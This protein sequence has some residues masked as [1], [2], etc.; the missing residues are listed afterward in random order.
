MEHEFAA[1]EVFFLIELSGESVVMM[2][3][4]GQDSYPITW[5]SWL[6]EEALRTSYGCLLNEHHLLYSQ[7]ICTHPSF[8]V[9]LLQTFFFSQSTQAWHGN[10]QSPT[11][12]ENWAIVKLWGTFSGQQRLWEQNRWTKYGASFTIQRMML[13]SGTDIDPTCLPC[14]SRRWDTKADTTRN[15]PWICIRNCEHCMQKKYSWGQQVHCG[16]F[17]CTLPVSTSSQRF[18]NIPRTSL[19]I[20]CI[21]TFPWCLSAD[22]AA[23][24]VLAYLAPVRCPLANLASLFPPTHTHLWSF[25]K[26]ELVYFSILSLVQFTTSPSPGHKNFWTCHFLLLLF[27]HF[28]SCP[29]VIWKLSRLPFSLTPHKNFRLVIFL[30]FGHCLNVVGL[31]PLVIFRTW[32]IMWVD[33]RSVLR[34][35]FRRWTQR[36]ADIL[37]ERPV[38]FFGTALCTFYFYL[39]CADICCPT[40]GWSLTPR[41]TSSGVI[42]SCALTAFLQNCASATRPTWSKIHLCVQPR[43]RCRSRR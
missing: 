29:R 18:R 4:G 8:L 11:T 26:V 38:V 9:N 27:V 22:C 24:V 40:R 5:N 19:T 13:C 39:P 20:S 36:A 16:S 32:P 2:Y 34:A 35:V 42:R 21:S 15:R 6:S 7:Q 33:L 31:S 3:E 14:E 28:G 10:R 30:N 43:W 25:P 23:V 41:R 37:L 12:G 17:T 1:R